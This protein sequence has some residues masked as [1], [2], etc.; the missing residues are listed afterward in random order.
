MNHRLTRHR[1]SKIRNPRAA[2]TAQ[3]HGFQIWPAKRQARHPRT[4]RAVV[5]PHDLRCE[6][7]SPKVFFVYGICDWIAVIE[8]LEHFT[9]GRDRNQ[10][11]EKN[12]CHPQ[13][14][15]RIKGKPIRVSLEF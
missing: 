11:V 10:F 13:I 5:C 8:Q 4:E 9:L 1:A 12:Q 2:Q 14:A 15:E 6:R 7:A 3:V